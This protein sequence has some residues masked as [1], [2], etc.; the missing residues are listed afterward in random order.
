V[1]LEWSLVHFAAYCSTFQLRI[2]QLYIAINFAICVVICCWYHWTDSPSIV[3]WGA[4]ALGRL[5]LLQ[6]RNERLMNAKTLR[7]SQGGGL[8]A[9]FYSVVLRKT[10]PEHQREDHLDL[11]RSFENTRF[12][13]P[14]QPRWLWTEWHPNETIAATSS[15]QS[16]LTRWPKS[17]LKS[18]RQTRVNSLSHSGWVVWCLKGS[19][20]LSIKNLNLSFTTS[21]INLERWGFLIARGSAD[22]C[23]H[24]RLW[25]PLHSNLSN[26]VATILATRAHQQKKMPSGCNNRNTTF[27]KNRND[28]K[29]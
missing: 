22:L 9:P 28:R 21:Q 5:I 25:T 17:W 16:K 3:I 4:F 6:N 19:Q 27:T 13:Q 10:S 11:T 24:F 1:H 2:W 29:I 18:W 15:S 26:N 12:S 23:E 8:V 20:A 14:R 7:R